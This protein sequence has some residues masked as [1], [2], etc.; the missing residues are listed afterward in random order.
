LELYVT[1]SSSRRRCFIHEFPEFNSQ[2]HT[3]AHCF[4]GFLYFLFQHNELFWNSNGSCI[5][6]ESYSESK[7][8]LGDELSMSIYDVILY[9]SFQRGYPLMFIDI[10]IFIAIFF[11]SR[12]FLFFSFPLDKRIFY[13][14]ISPHLSYLYHI[15]VAIIFLFSFS[16]D[17]SRIQFGTNCGSELLLFY[18]SFTVHT[19]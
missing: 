5:H 12:F 2:R 3:A 10:N 16:L 6:D 9:D 11:L 18:Y 4:I 19:R 13:G 7:A 17:I 15:F 1:C 14:W 8:G